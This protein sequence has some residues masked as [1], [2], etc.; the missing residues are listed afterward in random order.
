MLEKCK[1]CVAKE[2]ITKY[3][4]SGANIPAIAYINVHSRACV[5]HAQE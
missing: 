3:I 1:H 5:I 4:E 2:N